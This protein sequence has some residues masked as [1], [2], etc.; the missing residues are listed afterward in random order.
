MF[1]IFTFVEISL[2]RSVPF[3][4]LN[5]ANIKLLEFTYPAISDSISLFFSKKKILPVRIE[6]VSIPVIKNNITL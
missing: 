3:V 4:Q 5:S 2:I 1:E 6:T